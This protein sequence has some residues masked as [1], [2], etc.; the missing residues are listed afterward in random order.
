MARPRSDQRRN[1][2]L[3]AA[4]R[5]IASQ[6]L[7]ASTAA[8]AKEAGVSNGSLFLYFETKSALVNELYLLLKSEMGAAATDGLPTD[9]EP[10]EQLLHLWTGWFRWATGDPD[11]R[12]ALARLEVANEITEESRRHARET[13]TEM[14]AVLERCRVHGPMADQ[15]LDFVLHLA[16]A[17][18]ETTIDAAIRDPE[19]AAA[20]S[21][22]AF[23]AVCRLL[24]G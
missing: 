3:S 23:E 16:G 22:A 5:V 6:G 8:I 12:R 15:P 13:Q 4:T 18:S 1:A 20:R 19:V 17:I 11:G 10:R 9:A 2:I 14:A 24:L 21:D 7:G